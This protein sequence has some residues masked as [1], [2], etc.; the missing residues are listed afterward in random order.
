MATGFGD[1]QGLLRQAQ[2]MQRK[3]QDVQRSLGEQTVEGSAGGGAVKVV[4]SGNQDVVSVKILP[5][6]VDPTDVETLE[7]LVAGALKQAMQAA[8]QLRE[9]EMQKVTGGLNLP[10]MG[11]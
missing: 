4:V 5:A 8:R 1:M 3:L 2:D 7:A 11:F 6:A 9:R 10:G